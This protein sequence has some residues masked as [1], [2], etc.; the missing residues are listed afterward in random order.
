MQT[1]EMSKELKSTTKWYTFRRQI[2][3]VLSETFDRDVYELSGKILED[4]LRLRRSRTISGEVSSKEILELLVYHDKLECLQDLSQILGL[5]FNLKDNNDPE[6][7]I[8]GEM[9]DTTMT[10]LGGIT[11]SNLKIAEEVTSALL[12]PESSDT[13]DPE[14]MFWS[15]FEVL[16]KHNKLH[17]LMKCE[18]MQLEIVL[19]M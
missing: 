18:M 16:K 10:W 8:C 13:D 6:H 7:L 5:T 4:I 2:I 14:S 11:K 9:F 3:E 17:V 15:L 12:Y 19:L 1:T